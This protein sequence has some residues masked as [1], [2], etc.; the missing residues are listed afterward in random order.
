MTSCVGEMLAWIGSVGSCGRRACR[1]THA[2]SQNEPNSA[3]VDFL[4]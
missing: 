3:Y 2:V 4:E 1:L